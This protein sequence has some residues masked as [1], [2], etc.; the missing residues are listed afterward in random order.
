MDFDNRVSGV[1]GFFPTNPPQGPNQGNQTDAKV[2]SLGRKIIEGF[3]LIL[4]NFFTLGLINVFKAVREEYEPVFVSSLSQQGGNGNSPSSLSGSTDD[5]NIQDSNS[6]GKTVP[7]TINGKVKKENVQNEYKNIPFTTSEVEKNVRNYPKIIEIFN[8]SEKIN[9]ITADECRN[10]LEKCIKFYFLKDKEQFKEQKIFSNPKEWFSNFQIIRF[11]MQLRKKHLEYSWDL[12]HVSGSN[13]KIISDQIYNTIKPEGTDHPFVSPSDKRF[14]MLLNHNSSHWTLAFIDKEMETIEYYD[15]LVDYGN[16]EEITIQLKD[17][18][19]RL[20]YQYIDKTRTTKKDKLQKDSYQCGP[21]TCYF[22]E[23]RLKDNK[24]DPTKI[25]DRK[26]AQ[27]M[28][29]D[30]RTNILA[31]IILYEFEN[32]IAKYVNK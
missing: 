8:S 9:Q 26:K 23:N 14:P 4:A 28:I 16:Y 32:E 15:S 21:W 12:M 25:V 10:L 19:N 22:L 31:E 11:M 18:A 24:F 7:S 3:G 5:K 29:A 20:N 30:F 1:T 6:I 13:P 17:A 2:Y 27:T